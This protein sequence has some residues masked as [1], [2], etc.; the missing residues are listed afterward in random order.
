MN[1]AYDRI[2]SIEIGGGSLTLVERKVDPRRPYEDPP[3][4]PDR[5][6]LY[7]T[8]DETVHLRNM[9]DLRTLL[10]IKGVYLPVEARGQ[11]EPFAFIL[12][13]LL[14]IREPIIPTWRNEWM[15]EEYGV[16]LHDHRPY[17]NQEMLVYVIWPVTWDDVKPPLLEVT[18]DL[19]TLTHSV[20]EIG[21]SRTM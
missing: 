10:Q 9:D 12:G 6:V 16:D 3:S 8:D 13:S 17:V 18:L 19:T 4:A 20:H 7:V 15:K 14:H 2:R 21:H 11:E 5:H 1:N